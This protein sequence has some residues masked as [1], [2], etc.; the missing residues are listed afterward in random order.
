MAY[1]HYHSLSETQQKREFFRRKNLWIKRGD[2]HWILEH[3]DTRNEGRRYPLHQKVR[4]GDC[5]WEAVPVS[6]LSMEEKNQIWQNFPRIV[7]PPVR[8]VEFERGMKNLPK[9][10]QTHVIL[11]AMAPNLEEVILVVNERKKCRLLN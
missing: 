8:D 3:E 6:S 4:I 1:V 9:E 10:L 7:Y 2:C 5:R 11:E